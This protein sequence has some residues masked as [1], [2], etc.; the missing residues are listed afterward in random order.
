MKWIEDMKI[1]NLNFVVQLRQNQLSRKKFWYFETLTNVNCISLCLN[2]AKPLSWRDCS[3][4][5]FKIRKTKKEN[6]KKIRNMQAMCTWSPKQD[7]L[8]CVQKSKTLRR[9]LIQLFEK[10]NN[11]LLSNFGHWFWKAAFW[12]KVFTCRVI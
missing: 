5:A 8:V 10:L 3:F 12:R 7:W 4:S 1:R 2:S 9:D 11:D 6:F